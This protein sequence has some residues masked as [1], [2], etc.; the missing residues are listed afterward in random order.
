M[1]KLKE[2]P[3]SLYLLYA[4]LRILI[5]ILQLVWVF[6]SEHYDYVIMQNPPCVPLMSVLAM[7]KVTKLNKQKV[8]ID[9]HNYGYSIMRVNGVNKALVFIAKVYEMTFGKI[10][11]DYHLCVS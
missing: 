3:K 7:L 5:Q 2:L 9:W 10:A 6:Q 8:I 1:D 11:G 4:V